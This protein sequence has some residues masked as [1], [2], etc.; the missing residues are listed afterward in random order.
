MSFFENNKERVRSDLIK[1]LHDDNDEVPPPCSKNNCDFNN[2]TDDDDDNVDDIINL[3]N[4]VFK[5]VKRKNSN[6]SSSDKEIETNTDNEDTDKEGEEEEK[7]CA[8]IEKDIDNLEKDLKIVKNKYSDISL[9]DDEEENSDDDKFINN[10]IEKDIDDDNDIATTYI[11]EK[12]YK[13][14]IHSTFEPDG[15]YEE[16]SQTPPHCNSDYIDFDAFYENYIS[17]NSDEKQFDIFNDIIVEN[18]IHA[19]ESIQNIVSDFRK[20]VSQEWIEFM[21]EANVEYS[22]ALSDPKKWVNRADTILFD[23]YQKQPVIDYVHHLAKLLVLFDTHQTFS[24]NEHMYVD[25]SNK[26]LEPIDFKKYK[27]ED[28]MEYYTK[29]KHV[30]RILVQDVVDNIKIKQNVKTI[31]LLIDVY[32]KITDSSIKELNTCTDSQDLITRVKEQLLTQHQQPHLVLNR[33]IIYVDPD[34]KKIY[35]FDYRKL[36]DRFANGDKINPYTNKEF[37]KEFI[38]L[39]NQK[40]KNNMLCVFCKDKISDENTMLK[41]IYLH[42]KYGP[43][44]LKFCDTTCMSDQAWTNKALQNA[45]IGIV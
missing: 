37:T 31:N 19:D 45:I 4:D 7:V 44:I 3:T 15:E 43:I 25:I 6:S 34:T 36:N 18:L 30:S 41:T 12:P 8:T 33:P 35:I 24:L 1:L 27:L 32:N 29:G 10:L 21:I 23:M 38:E 9:F 39:C 14:E 26:A 20:K 11:D 13:I 2:D 22:L 16:V 28:M 17:N 5:S 42:P 40:M